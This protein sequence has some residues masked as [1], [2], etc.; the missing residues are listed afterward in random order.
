M[1]A[2]PLLN[3]VF[4]LLLLLLLLLLR[5]YYYYVIIIIIIIIN[6]V[7]NNIHTHSIFATWTLKYTAVV[8][9]RNQIGATYPHAVVLQCS[10]V[11]Y[12]YSIVHI[13]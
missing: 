7:D 13:L 2:P 9:R 4:L 6:S 11:Q 5:Y 8:S 1:L 10:A 12:I 3:S